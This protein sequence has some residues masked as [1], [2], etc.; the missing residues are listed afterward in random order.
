MEEPTPL[1]VPTTYLQKP[2]FTF[3]GMTWCP[4]CVIF[5]DGGQGKP[6]Q[7]PIML[8]DKEL[9]SKVELKRIEWNSKEK[10]HQGKPMKIIPRPPGYDFANYG[11]FFVLEAGTAVGEGGKPQV[12]GMVYRGQD[13]TAAGI[14]SWI[15]KQ[16]SSNPLFT[17]K[18]NTSAP[19]ATAP[20][21]AITNNNNKPASVIASIPT[22]AA[23]NV[24]TKTIATP[25]Q[26]EAS[27]SSASGADRLRSALRAQQ[28]QQSQKVPPSPPVA[29]NIPPS[30]VS[31]K[32]VAPKEDNT[33]SFR[34]R[35]GTK[36]RIIATYD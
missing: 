10:D 33:P 16:L 17:K 15:L 23:N 13:R 7:W 4:H 35:T 20:R 2:R 28:Q 36:T 21:P 27:G 6:A 19:S 24:T 5:G 8:A 9:N 31:Q 3:L 26:Q 25:I 22:K 18:G 11:P 34:Y 29:D 14:K 1:K 12:V 30:T 32:K